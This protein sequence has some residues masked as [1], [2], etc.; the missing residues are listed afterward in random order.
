MFQVYRARHL[1]EAQ[2]LVE[3]LERQGIDTYIRNQDLIGT[4]LS[5]VVLPEVCVLDEKDFERARAI[6]VEYENMLRAEVVGDDRPCPNCRAEN[7]PNFETCWS[8]RESMP[9]PG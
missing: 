5:G 6:S 1:A 8:C 9:P 7:P 2:L 3:H 4:E